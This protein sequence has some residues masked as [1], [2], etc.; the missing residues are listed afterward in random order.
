[1]FATRILIAYTN[2]VVCISTIALNISGV[3]EGAKLTADDAYLIRAL[4][5]GLAQLFHLRLKVGTTMVQQIADMFGTLTC[6]SC[7]IMLL[8]KC[9]YLRIIS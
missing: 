7:E 5:A 8:S 9:V 1:M 6:G 4:V 3:C 2:I